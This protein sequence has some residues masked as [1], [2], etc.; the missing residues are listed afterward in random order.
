MSAHLH[1]LAATPQSVHWGGRGQLGS[2]ITVAIRPSTGSFRADGS[3]A[4]GQRQRRLLEAEAVPYRGAR[5]LLS[6]ARL[7][8]LD[9]MR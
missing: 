7:D 3:L 5:V 2:A 4:K 1:T 6:R 8:D 9:A